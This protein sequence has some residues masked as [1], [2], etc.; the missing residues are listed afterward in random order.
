MSWALWNSMDTPCLSE[1]RPSTSPGLARFKGKQPHPTCAFNAKATCPHMISEVAAICPHGLPEKHAHT[2][3][4]RGLGAS[5]EHGLRDRG[6]P[7]LRAVHVR[8]EALLGCSRQ[9]N[10]W[11]LCQPAALARSL[12]VFKVM[13]RP[14]SEDELLWEVVPSSRKVGLGLCDLKSD[15]MGEPP[16][17]GLEKHSW[18]MVIMVER[19][20]PSH[21]VQRLVS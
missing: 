15:I 14:R 17:R 6:S 20:P 16:V 2:R 7:L 11:L 3:P 10:T 9:S 21:R 19:P 8:T 5:G 18:V 12:V 4:H 13:I 1:G